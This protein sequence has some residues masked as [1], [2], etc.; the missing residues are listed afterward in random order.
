MKEKFEAIIGSL[1]GTNEDEEPITGIE[2]AEQFQAHETTPEATL[3]NLNAAFLI[4]LCGKSH[5]LHSQAEYL[6]KDLEK[7]PTWGHAVEFYQK[8]LSLVSAEIEERCAKNEDFREDMEQLYHWIKNPKN[9]S[10]RI[11]TTNKVWQ[12]FFPEGASLLENREHNIESLRKKRN[13]RITL[14]NPDPIK[15]PASEILFTSNVLLTIPTPSTDVET[16]SLPEKVQMRLKEIKTGPQVYWYD[17]PIQIGVERS[18]NE[19]VYGLKGL[20][21]AIEFEK[22][23]GTVEKDARVHCLLSV[24]VT[25]AGLQEIAKACIEKMLEGGNDLHHLHVYALTESDTQRMVD[26]VLVPAAR[27]YLGLKDANS[28]HE[29]IGVD[30]EY[31][32]HYNFLKTISALWHVFLDPSVRATFKIDLDQVFPQ[33]ELVEETGASA[34]EHLKTPLWGAKGIDQD[35][36]Q[37]RLGMIAGALVNQKDIAHSLFTP[38]VG[39]PNLKIKGDEWVFY[40][41]LPQAIST[42]SEM[43]TRYT[44]DILNGRDY[45]IQRVHV[46]GGTCG[47]LVESLRRHRAFTPSF[48][49]RAEDQAYLL[50]VLFEGSEENLR[51]VHKDGLIMR[52]DKEGFASEAIRTSSTGKVVGDYARSLLF[53]YYA[54]ALPWPV[55]QTKSFIDPFTGCFVS[56]IPF[57]I[58]YLR[59]ALKAASLFKE[60]KPDEGLE[61]LQIGTARLFKIIKEIVKHPNSLNERYLYEKRAWGIYY[62]LLDSVERALKGGDPFALDLRRKAKCL[63][64][65]C[66]ISSIVRF[67]MTRSNRLWPRPD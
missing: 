30:G 15:D 22:R 43:M 48:I 44:S 52:H 42:E 14:L 19:A 29:I 31:G 5:P 32:K 50:S 60:G 35:G 51:Y 27:H 26:E 66:E 10:N 23:R 21:Q 49:G 46:T 37:V 6:I 67:Y 65:D 41:P 16:L 12:V 40:S 63:I 20:N 56:Y 54:D 64:R 17:H 34:L 57:T 59:L 7:H 58:V 53:S 33:D 3:R 8:G 47:I 61:L 36:T 13:V 4:C 2:I 39:F 38:D 24:S 45:C 25:H 62:D 28:L 18:K 55:Q 9:L 11:E 1:I